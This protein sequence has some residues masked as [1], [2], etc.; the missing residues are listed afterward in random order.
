MRE[1][2]VFVRL[3]VS[4]LLVAAL[5]PS[6]SAQIGLPPAWRSKLDPLL[7]PR[8]SL[9]VGRSRI[10]VRAAGV[11]A[12]AAIGTLVQQLGGTLGRPLPIIDGLAIDLP[13]LALPVLAASPLVQRLSLD[14]LV[15]GALERT[16]ATIGA[17]AVR[18]DAGYDGAGIGVAI[19][20]SGITPW[21]DDL[22]APAGGAQRVDLFVDLVN[23]R[24]VAYD[25]YGHGTHVAGI[26]A[27][28]G[29]DSAGAR[30]G[31]APAARLL[32][33][34]ALDASGRGRISDVIA[35]LGYV[36]I[37]QHALNIRVVNLSLAT[38][39]YES[40]NLDPLTLAAQRVAAAGIVVV[41]AAGN[42]GRS[43]Q[44]R[45]N[46][47]GVTAPG[48][49][50]WVLTIG[51]SSHM[52]SVARGDD[53]IAAFSSRG[54]GAV[55]YGAKPDIVA[56]GVG[57]ESLSDPDSAFYVSRSAYLL[58]GSVPTSYLP[59]LSLSGT[60]MAAP[61]VTGTVALMLQANPLLT[62]N[63]VKAILQYTAQVHPDH[64][65]LTQGA[66]FLNAGG[67][68][69]LARFLGGPATGASPWSPDWG[70]GIIWGNQLLHGGRLTADANAWSTLVTWGAARTPI[71][72]LV[73]WGVICTA[74]ACAPDVGPWSR[75]GAECSGFA[76]SSVAW[77]DGE[78]RNVVWGSTCGGA[79]CPTPWSIG[80]AGYLL[81]GSANGATVV[82][83]TTYDETVVWGTTCSDPS[84]EPVIWNNQ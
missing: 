20:D 31:I 43:A 72:H 81:S 65:P 54:P 73:D 51:A 7:Q 12:L 83:G 58:G 57:I 48:N 25:D 45:T 11:G 60:S 8:A 62:P 80:V 44:G 40:Y 70:G 42:N 63:L 3:I 66:G 37:Y 18:A 32:A 10:I 49:A 6:T 77:G 5:V 82:W 39:V 56:P 27:G 34:K 71:G 79:D 9:L 14:R 68:V 61:V 46:Y 4:L 69:Q 75:W 26:V 74:A 22:S 28:N 78:S 15:V 47:G 53:T 21:H 17:T 19:I 23:G 41:A 1:A 38:G 2:P 16:S 52:G 59:Y 50:P 84:C 64:D 55:D 67:A 36:L 35:A 24:S 76:C 29:H 33:I 13:H 30:S